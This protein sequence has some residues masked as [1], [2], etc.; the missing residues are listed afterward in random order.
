MRRWCR[1]LAVCL[2]GLVR[3][4][5]QSGDATLTGTVLDVVGKPIPSAAV[6]VKNEST[7]SSHQVISGPDG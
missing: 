1:V 3:L 6:S 4:Q 2:F 7:G 5:A